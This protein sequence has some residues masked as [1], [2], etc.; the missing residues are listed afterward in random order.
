M[1]T[2]LLALAT[3]STRAAA[4][5]I[6]HVVVL[7]EE[8]RAFDHL[9]GYQ[10]ALKV[11]G[12]N[13]DESNPID[14]RDPSK[15]SVK[16]FDG[17]PYVAVEQP[18]HGYAP[19]QTKLDVQDGVPRMD[20]FVAFERSVHR[21]KS[22][23]DA[24]MQGFSDG[25]LPVSTALAAEFAVFDN[26]FTAFPGAS[27]PNHMFSYSAT[28]NGITNTGDGYLCQKDR[29]FPQRTIFDALL[30]SGHEYVRIYNDSITD[31][32]MESFSSNATRSRTHTMD[33]FFS[34][35][36]K[37]TLP[38]LTWIDPRQGV[39]QS[40]GSLG[41]PNSDHPSC[42]DVAL[43]ERLRKDIYEALRAGPGWNDTA[44][45][46]TWDD[47]GGF[48]DHVPPPMS[49]PPP[50]HQPAC[51]CDEGTARCEGFEPYS[52]LGSRVPV[53]VVSPW[54]PKGSVVSAP[55]TK[56]SPTSQFDGTSIVA[57]IKRC[58]TYRPS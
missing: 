14:P 1:R 29:P 43:G 9:L 36:A 23:A 31:V 56:P 17:A 6:K 41:G 15:G 39:N 10:K 11:N 8:N 7:Y 54:V 50:D 47:P 44:L 21:N 26:W 53:I 3:L 25:A 30:E 55:R 38:A 52:R 48:F 18:R 16:V 2:A 24:V 37:G 34:D 4:H 19:Y 20:G 22:I 33:R 35:A 51:W 40:L 27:W 12:L 58:L 42:C 32:F 13:G 5:R 46:M 49:A 57:T 45:V 28:A